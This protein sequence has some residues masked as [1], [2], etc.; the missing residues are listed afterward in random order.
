MKKLDVK[1]IALNAV[2]AAVYAALTIGLA[3]ISYGQVQMGCRWTR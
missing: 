1:T 2:I 3:P